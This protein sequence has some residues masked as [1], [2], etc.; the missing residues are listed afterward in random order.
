MD[1]KFGQA[2]HGPA[3]VIAEIAQAHDGSLGTAHAFIDAVAKAGADAVKFQTHIAHAEST[4]DEPWRVHF[5]RQDATR[6]DYWQRM[7]FTAAQW[8][9]LAEHA[10]EGGLEFLSSPFSVAAVELLTAIDVPMWKIASGEITNPELLEAV[11]ATGQPVLFSS[12]M[13]EMSE[14]DTVVAE[15]RRREIP[16]AVFQC[17]SSY[18]CPPELWG[19]HVMEELRQRYD[20]P[21]GLSDHSGTIFAGLAAASLGANFVEVHVTFSRQAFGPD[22]P[23]S[24]TMEEFAEMV[25]GI[26]MINTARANTTPKNEAAEQAAPLKTIFGRSWALKEDLPAGAVIGVEDLTLKK[27]ANGIPYTEKDAILGRRLAR[28]K[29]ADRLLRWEDFE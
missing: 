8:Q 20:C 11:W 4:Y 16:F 10:R 24:V 17:S 13:S 15:T 29:S 21:V 2:Q 6:Y 27:P 14:L 9:E 3:Y 25:R 28:D 5:S 12:G 1:M 7:E 26:R 19:L 22:V 23:A 18:P